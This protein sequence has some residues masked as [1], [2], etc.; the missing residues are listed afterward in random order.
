MP[1]VSCKDICPPSAAR[2]GRC[3][4]LLHQTALHRPQDQLYS[5]QDS[6]NILRAIA[7][8]SSTSFAHDLK[9]G[10]RGTTV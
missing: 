9:Q 2:D 3:D 8:A 6:D 7:Y 4:F 5:N 10:R 1:P